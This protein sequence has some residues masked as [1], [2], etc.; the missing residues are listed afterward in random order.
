MTLEDRYR[1]LLRWYPRSWRAELE[2]VMLGTLLD[3]AE[4]RGDARPR[5]AEAWSLRVNGAGERLT[6][7]SAVACAIAAVLLTA[8][9]TVMLFSGA[10]APV[11]AMLT[12]LGAG[13]AVSFAVV[14]LLRSIRAVSP[15]GAV[16]ALAAAVPAWAL[17]AL[18]GAAWSIGFDRADAGA[19]PTPFTASFPLLLACGWA[20]GAIAT[21]IVAAGVL[22]GLPR[23]ARWTVAA[24]VAAVTPLV[25]GPTVTSGMSGVLLSCTVLIIATLRMRGPASPR[26]ARMPAVPLAASA[27]RWSMA[28]TLL[29]LVA[30]T[31]GAAFA[32]FGSHWTASVDGTRAM[33]LGL[34]AGQLALIPLALLLVVHGGRRGI[35][36]VA[37][38]GAGAALIAIG[39]AWYA[40]GNLTGAS[41]TGDVPWVALSI[42]AAGAGVSAFGSVRAEGASRWAVA[43]S[44]AVG[45]L[46][47][48]WM[49]LQIA[50]FVVPV[51]SA[52]IL[53]ATARRRGP[54][55]PAT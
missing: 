20:A 54:R 52:A 36:A 40:A 37:V 51:A 22:S 12:S 11:G 55:V 50:A 5:P 42:I 1:R 15:A 17:A 10:T 13:T 53:T 26:E 18:A 23:L 24:L 38:L 46:L 14:G 30:A 44:V 45:V 21:A 35:E 16:S 4:H 25:L 2:E 8:T 49:A 7:R 28:L 34:G 47:T 29:A 41:G 19:P 48:A 9:T 6:A 27:R 43:G 31:A 32:L 33:Q 3:A 39:A